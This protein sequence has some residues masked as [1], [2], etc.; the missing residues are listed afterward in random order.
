MSEGRYGVIDL[1][2]GEIIRQTNNKK[3][4]QVEANM[5]ITKEMLD[6]PS[7]DLI[8]HMYKIMKTS[9]K[10][11]RYGM[12]QVDGLYV[13]EDFFRIGL[14]CGKDAVN[15]IRLKY[16]LS[17]RGFIKQ[18][19]TTDCHTWDEVMIVLGIVPTNKRAVKRFKKVLVDNDVVRKCYLPSGIEVFVV[20]PNI[21]RHGSHTSALCISTFK[22]IVL[23]R[24]D[25][26]NTYLMYLN[27]LLEYSDLK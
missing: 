14:L 16:V 27:G 10:I 3:L 24:V 6:N 4:A 8:R 15:F 5:L 25:R 18:T 17:A 9:G 11:D 23:D 19:S 7:E 20:N 1:I 22:D 26:Y 2:T 13:G 12:I 21:L